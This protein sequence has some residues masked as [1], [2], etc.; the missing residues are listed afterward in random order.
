MAERYGRTA[1]RGGRS[2]VLDAAVDNFQRLGYHG[3][4][5]RDIARDANMTVASIYHHFPSKQHILQDIMVRAMSDVISLTRSAL[6]SAG[7]SP[8]DQLAAVVRAWI[9]FHTD[10]RA[11]AT[12][13]ATEIRSLD[14]QGHVLV[15]MLRDQQER[16]FRDI[17]DRGVTEGAFSTPYPLEAVRAIITMGYS[18]AAWYRPDGRLTP[19][20]LADRYV[21]LALGTVGA[22]AVTAERQSG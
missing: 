19:P 20:V 14:E 13:G 11:E 5:V 8:Q 21:A 18:I 2:A 17:V 10:R 3:T 6:M 15:V 7:P 22:A 9:L 1:T 16:M 4:S 12:I